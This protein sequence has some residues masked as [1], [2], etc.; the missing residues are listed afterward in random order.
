MTA[1]KV[2]VL[3]LGIMGG[4]MARNLLSGGFDMTVWNRSPAKADPLVAAGARLAAT[5]AEAA[6]D[7]DIV[8]AMLADDD[9]SRQ[10]WLSE[11]DGALAAMKAG[12]I[13]IEASTLTV[14]WVRTLNEAMMAHGAGFLDAPVTGSRQQAAEGKLRFLV[15]GDPDVLA[16]AEPAFAAMGSETVHLGPTGSGATL[17]LVNNFL[18]GVQVASLAEAIAM[19]ERS[20]LDVRRA[21]SILTGGAPGSPLLGA[22]SARMLD[23]AY[24]PQFLVP[25]MAKDLAYAEAAFAAAEIPLPSAAAARERFDAAARAGRQGS[26]IAAIIEPLRCK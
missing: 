20:G 3:G 9:A 1:L 10:A 11:T 16:R 14:D 6:H 7:A 26:D 2:A 12:A 21:V 19:I 5:P 18:C 13:G 25:L 22:V 23:R 8:V 4:G 15:G 24:E 17:K